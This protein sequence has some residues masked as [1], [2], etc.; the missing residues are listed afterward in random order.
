MS[1]I[2]GFCALA[3][4][5]LAITGLRRAFFVFLFCAGFLPAYVAIPLGI[6]GAGVSL[7]QIMTL[8]MTV[9][10]VLSFLYKPKPWLAALS[11]AVFSK[12]SMIFLLLY[13]CK[14]ISIQTNNFPNATFYMIDEMI[15]MYTMFLLGARYLSDLPSLYTGLRLL[16]AGAIL[17]WFTI[18]LEAVM[19][20]P[21]L[22]SIV[23]VQVTTVGEDVLQGFERAGAYRNQ[24]FF[25]HPLSLAEYTIYVLTFLFGIKKMSKSR[26]PILMSL[27]IA[28]TLASTLST[29][30]R[31]AFIAGP[32]I[33]A[34]YL[35]LE[36]PRFTRRSTLALYKG[37]V[38]L[39]VAL[40]SYLVVVVAQN[41]DWF[42][43]TFSFLVGDDVSEIASVFSRASQYDIIPREVMN[44]GFMGVFGE[45]HRSDFITR[46]DTRLD[47]Y[48]L[49][50]MIEGGMLGWVFFSILVIYSILRSRDF[51]KYGY[52]DSINAAMYFMILFFVSFAINKLFL[53]M[54]FNNW[55][56][57][58]FSG[59]MISLTQNIKISESKPTLATTK[60][61]VLP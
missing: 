29:G 17:Q 2:V 1:A 23:Q 50:T 33:V 43:N 22:Q 56:F 15:R 16:V 24:G 38:V 51:L 54:N 27:L 19:Q 59:S 40:G 4:L 18:P 25:D 7:M 52:D 39:S 36:R 31:F 8:T 3:F 41:V 44:S 55:L 35:F 32:I 13:A 28:I 49:R 11:P 61:M 9:F 60:N 46:F 10:V 45:G 21:L 53:S 30:T 37:G 57:F 12:F 5:C 47:N 48:Y 26:A 34:A 20:G 14:F 42:V 6:G 58:V